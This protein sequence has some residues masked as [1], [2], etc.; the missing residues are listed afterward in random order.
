[1]KLKKSYSMGKRTRNWAKIWRV[2]AI[3]LVVLLVIS[4]AF[5]RMHY[6]NNLKPVSASQRT[7]TVTIPVGASVTEI[8]EE[9]KNRDVIKSPW[10]FEWYVRNHNVRDRLQAGTYNIRP[11]QSVQ[12]IVNILAQGQVATDLVTILPGQRL[13]QVRGALVA[14]GFSAES[15]DAALKADQYSDMPALADKP[16]GANLEGY[17]YPDSYART[18]ET[19]PEQIIRASLQEMHKYITPEIRSSMIKQGLTP[20]EGVILASIIEQEVS[21]SEDKQQVAQVFLRR[22]KSDKALESDVTGVYGALKDGKPPLLTYDSAYN[23]FFH[24][25]LPP[26]PI[27]NVS[28]DSILAV[29]NPA[30]T[31]YLYFVAGDDGETYFSRT[32]E[33]HEHLTELHCKKLCNR[34]E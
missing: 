16:S 7:V 19:T 29:A 28:K 33:E 12:D 18:A 8:A 1:M 9:L 13:D 20:H 10:A 27:S 5:L 4:M 31:D 3:V 11:S 23:T 25:G 24:K 17:L 6:E 22:L 34:A 14:A 30:K 21:N 32:L 2:S 15:V 26:G